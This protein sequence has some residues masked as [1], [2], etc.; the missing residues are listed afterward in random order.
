MSCLILFVT[1]KQFTDVKILYLG[2][3]PVELPGGH[4]MKG[5][6][7]MLKLSTFYPMNLLF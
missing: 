5:N 6:A 3:L 2:I 7:E 4:Q 1:S